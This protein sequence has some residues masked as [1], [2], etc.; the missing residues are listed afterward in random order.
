MYRV[1][2][3]LQNRDCTSPGGK[4]IIQCGILY[5]KKTKI[6]KPSGFKSSQLKRS[7]LPISSVFTFIS[8]TNQTTEF[9]V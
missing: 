8:I 5:E 3:K 7:N 4:N 9:Y 6:Q 2:C 1:E